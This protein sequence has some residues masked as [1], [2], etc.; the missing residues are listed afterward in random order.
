MPLFISYSHADAN[1]VE[2]LAKQLVRHKHY[3]WLDKW[4]LNVGDSLIQRIQSALHLTPGLIVVLSKASVDSEWCKKEL[5]SGLLRELEEK[6]V[7]VFPVIKDDCELPLFVRG[8][9]Y[10]DFRTNFDEGFRSLVE[11][12]SKITNTSQ[13]RVERPDFHTDWAVDWGDTGGIAW[14]RFVLLDHSP[15]FPYSC[16]TE[17]R[18]SFDRATSDWFQR[19]AAADKTEYAQ[20]QIT[21]VLAKQLAR[22][23]DLRVLL[24]DQYIKRVTLE[25][26]DDTSPIRFMVEIMARRLG[27]DTGRDVLFDVGSQLMKIYEGWKKIVQPPRNAV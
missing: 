7:I 14:M 9:V 17:V 12:V 8:K 21:E 11:A 16:H 23:G 18:F 4:E 1:F 20:L 25:C 22:A 6:R 10:A 26:I 27:E 15:Q 3:V 13:G 2:T 24:P 19:Q 5:E